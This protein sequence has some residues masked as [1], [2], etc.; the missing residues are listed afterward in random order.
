MDATILQRNECFSKHVRFCFTFQESNEESTFIRF[1][2][3]QP[4]SLQEC[5]I[6]YEDASQKSNKTF[7]DILST[8]KV[9]RTPYIFLQA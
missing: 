2:L 8:I 1:M 9:G 6:V 7:E 5:T 3:I 4:K